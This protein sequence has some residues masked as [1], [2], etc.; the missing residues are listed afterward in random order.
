MVLNY[1]SF[2][3]VFGLVWEGVSIM[4]GFHYIFFYFFFFFCIY[5][6]GWKMI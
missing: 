2:V 6:K 5:K 1:S 3:L 4:Q